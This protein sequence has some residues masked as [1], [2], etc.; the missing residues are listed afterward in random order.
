M[1]ALTVCQPYAEL[2]ASGVKLVENRTWETKYRGRFYVHAGRSREWLDDPGEYETAADRPRDYGIP[3]SRMAFGCV[4]AIATLIDCVKYEDIQ[5]GKY[6]QTYPWLPT[7]EHTEGPW[8]WILGDNV[9]RVG[10]YRYKGQQGLFDINPAN[11]TRLV[12]VAPGEVAR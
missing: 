4:I 12:E 2:I 5:A 8:C 3:L 11:L 7:H 9:A 1:K 10:P 6:D